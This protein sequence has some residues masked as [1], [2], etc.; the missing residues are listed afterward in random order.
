MYV[1][2][3]ITQEQFIKVLSLKT[4][5]ALNFFEAKA[6]QPS[7]YELMSAKERMV[8]A[9]NHAITSAVCLFATPVVSAYGTGTKYMKGEGASRYVI[10]PLLGVAAG[11]L[12]IGVG[13][14][15]FLAHAAAAPLSLLCGAF[16]HSSAS[17]NA[18]FPAE[19]SKPVVVSVFEP[20]APKVPV[21]HDTTGMHT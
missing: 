1:G 7:D 10:A 12:G 15:G 4:P 16:Y 3:K 18:A 8:D 19:S 6:T 2:D 14:A 11:V 21:T 17:L 20:E 5:D 9:G 13:V